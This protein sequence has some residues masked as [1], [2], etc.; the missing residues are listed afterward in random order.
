VQK[1][2]KISA[3]SPRQTDRLLFEA[4]E[5]IKALRSVILR[6]DRNDGIGRGSEA[7]LEA[8]EAVDALWR[9]AEASSWMLRYILLDPDSAKEFPHLQKYLR[10]RAAKAKTFPVL[11]NEA[12]DL[13]PYRTLQI[14][15]R[16]LADCKNPKKRSG[17]SPFSPYALQLFRRIDYLRAEQIAI[18]QGT[19]HEFRE[20]MQFY[21]AFDSVPTRRFRAHQNLPAEEFDLRSKIHRAVPIRPALLAELPEMTKSSAR[22]WAD[23]A[24]ELFLIAFPDPAKIAP[25]RHAVRNP[26]IRYESEIRA[27][28]VA[29]IGRA[30]LALANA[31]N[32]T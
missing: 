31:G 21:S 2:R 3:D 10:Q 5:R 30:V 32:P 1:V 14:G 27:Q 20:S 12:V 29:R 26:N 25:L 4:T 6:S 24:K 13:E 8:C 15:Y 9:I 18:R 22:V 17:T 23:R 28:I 16:N 11:F 7:D 19:V